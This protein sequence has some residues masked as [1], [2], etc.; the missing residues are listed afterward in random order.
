LQTR[1]S[2]VANVERPSA[3]PTILAGALR[4]TA[5]GGELEAVA[6]FDNRR[7]ALKGI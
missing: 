6:V 5:L 4:E 2:P 3:S 7:I 1:P